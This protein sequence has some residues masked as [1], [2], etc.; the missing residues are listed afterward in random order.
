MT[1]NVGQNYPYTSESDGERIAHVA[2][3]IADRQDLADK[4]KAE[5]T[6][7]DANDRWWVYKCPSKGCAGLLH[8]AGYAADKHAVF[9]V[10]DGTCAKTFL[11]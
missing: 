3:L 11:R 10:C 5:T 8:A 7:L 9:V 4:I 6:P 1:S 2:S